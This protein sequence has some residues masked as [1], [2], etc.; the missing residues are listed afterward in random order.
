M[1]EYIPLTTYDQLLIVYL[2]FNSDVHL[3]IDVIEWYPDT[4]NRYE[5]TQG[6]VSPITSTHRYLFLLV[7]LARLSKQPPFQ[8]W[9]Y[10]EVPFNFRIKSA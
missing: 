7:K 5:Y 10:L 8:I 9:Y 4:I 2:S 6:C 1:H 3:I